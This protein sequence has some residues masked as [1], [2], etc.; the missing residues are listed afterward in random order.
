M[1]KSK[2]YITIF[3]IIINLL[4]FSCKNILIDSNSKIFRYNESSG[5][6]SLDPMF[7]NTKSNI[8]AVNHIFNGLVDLDE[9]LN[10]IP[11]IA[12]SWIKSDDGL[13]YL[14]F[15]RDDVFFHESTYFETENNTF[16][17]R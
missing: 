1:K 13:E 3:L 10:I 2:L 8:W 4:F 17:K 12:H 11:C 16:E 15:L 6:S 5:I 14:F 9:D 7:S